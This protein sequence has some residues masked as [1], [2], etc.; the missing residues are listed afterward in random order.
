MSNTHACNYVVYLQILC[1]NTRFVQDI[2][3]IHCDSFFL[4]ARGLSLIY[5]KKEQVTN[6]EKEQSKN[7]GEEKNNIDV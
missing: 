5:Y 3:M 1:S 4:K 7:G 2:I 6:R